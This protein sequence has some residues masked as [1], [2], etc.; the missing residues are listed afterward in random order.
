MTHH[1]Y[2]LIGPDG[3][4]YQS[5]RKGTLGGHRRS[6]VYGRLDCPG[7]LRALARGGPYPKFRVFFADEAT[8]IAAGYRPCWL[9]MRAEYAA[10]KRAHLRS[11]C[12]ALPARQ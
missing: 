11:E 3:A 12:R 5:T 7:A 8:A 9:C 6:K 1:T 4:A 2:R 10:W